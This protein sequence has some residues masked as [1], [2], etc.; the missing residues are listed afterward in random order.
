MPDNYSMDKGAIDKKKNN[1]TDFAT[2]FRDEF[3]KDVQ[4]AEVRHR[5]MNYHYLQ[6]KGI[7][8]LNDVYGEEYMKTIGLQV[9]VPRTF[10]TVEAIRP[11]LIDREMDIDVD[12]ENKKAF[13]YTAKARDILKGETKRSK[14]KYQKADAETEALLYGTGYLFSKYYEDVIDTDILDYYDDDGKPV[15]KKGTLD[16]YKGMKAFRLNPYHVFRDRNATTNEPGMPGTWDHCYV[17]SIWD[18]ETWKEICK[19]EGYNVEGMEKGGYLRDFEE[20]KRKIDTIY[21]MSNLSSK[22][23]NAGFVNADLELLAKDWEDSIM[24][25]EK[26]EENHYSICSGANWTVNCKDPNPNPDKR[27]PIFPIKDYSVPGEFEGIGEPEVMRWQQYEENKIHNLS[28][29]QT[30]MGTVQRFGVVKELLVDPTSVKNNNPFNPIYLK[31]VP[32]ISINNAIQALNQGKGTQYPKEFLAEVKATGQSATGVS[33]FYIGGSKAITDTATEANKL[34]DAT[35][36]RISRKIEEMEDRGITPILEHWLACIPYFYD[37]EL[38]LLV[39]DNENYFTKFLP[40]TRDY[41]ENLNLVATLGVKEGVTNATTLEEIYL[42][43]GYKNVVF[44]SDILNRFGITIK[45]NKNASNKLEMIRQFREVI[46]EMELVN[47]TLMATGQP[48]KYDTAKLREELLRQFPDI[49]EDPAEYVLEVPVQ[50]ISDINN[51]GNEPPSVTT[52]A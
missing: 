37:E 27:I 35:L 25:V 29:L 17:Y 12:P 21:S 16:R 38:D 20:V 44:V 14:F 19:V 41:N 15:T 3:F 18:F 7:L 30:L 5:M 39:T 46:T 22:D 2:K 9:N 1:D 36:A 45:P 34:A 33:D 48:A 43:T 49:I 23:N 24:V 51:T 6:Y 4:S 32:N 31:Y 28:Y 11:Q 13:P 40:Y 52:P 42:K 47:Q 8:Y 10:M 26:F 50:Q